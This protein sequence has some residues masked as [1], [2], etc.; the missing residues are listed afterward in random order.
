M[1]ISVHENSYA[2]SFPEQTTKNPYLYLVMCIIQKIKVLD[3]RCSL[4]HNAPPD[5]F[6]SQYME[7]AIA[8]VFG[9]VV[10][11]SFI[12]FASHFKSQILQK[13]TKSDS[14]CEFSGK[15]NDL[16]SSELRKM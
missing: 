11:R 7:S 4:L 14:S 2:S 10:S 12:F 3:L 1:L 8:L 16:S 13:I 6:S 15:K 9:N 5:L